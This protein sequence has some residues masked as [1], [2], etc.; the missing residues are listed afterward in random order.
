MDLKEIEAQIQRFVRPTTFPIGVKFL[1]AS[2]DVPPRTRFPLGDLG[3]QIMTCQS[4]TMARRYGW[5]VGMR[6]E[7]LK[8]G[9][10]MIVPGFVEAP[11]EYY[12]GK[13]D[14][15]PSTQS[16][17]IRSIRLRAMDRLPLNEGGCMV[18]APLF[19]EAFEPDI[20]LVYGTPAQV[21]RLVQASLYKSGGYLTFKSAG[22][23]S[24]A[25]TLATPIV[26]DQS[27]LVLVG[28]GERIFGHAEDVELCF[29][30]PRSQIENTISGFQPTHDG[31]QRYP[32]PIN[33]RFEPDIPDRYMKLTN[34]LKGGQT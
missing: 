10:G 21:L 11:L 22:G 31:G 9:T 25:E 33:I 26:H 20:Y 8:C 3:I 30:I 19:K 5:I 7:D 17:E 16:P 2:E 23:A 24:C 15:T 34:A 1:K 6:K 13:F 12:E 4:F 28:N 14:L 29:A 18:V 27:T 32:I